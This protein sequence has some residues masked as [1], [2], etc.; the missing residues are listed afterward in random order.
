MPAYRS[1]WQETAWTTSELGHLANEH[2]PGLHMA[3]HHPV[4]LLGQ[5]GRLFQDVVGN[6]QLADVVQETGDAQRPFGLNPRGS[7]T[8][9]ASQRTRRRYRSGSWCSGVTDHFVYTKLGIDLPGI[10]A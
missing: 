9:Q 5:R 8:P 7:D 4:F 10:A 6:Y 1:W 2:L 3:L